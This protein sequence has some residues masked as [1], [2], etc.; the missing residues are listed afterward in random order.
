M[1]FISLFFFFHIQIMVRDLHYIQGSKT[2]P[3]VLPP[4]EEKESVLKHSGKCVDH[5]SLW[6]LAI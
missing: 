4:L 3:K 2:L 6:D 1:L 5:V